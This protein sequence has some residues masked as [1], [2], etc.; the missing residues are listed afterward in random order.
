[1]Q[2]INWAIIEAS[3]G[4]DPRDYDDDTLGSPECECGGE[5]T[6]IGEQDGGLVMFEC[7]RCGGEFSIVTRKTPEVTTDR[8]LASNPLFADPAPWKNPRY[9]D[10]QNAIAIQKFREKHL[11]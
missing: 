2:P 3:G 5:S 8:Q 7:V 9:Q 11:N 4:Y 6:Y 10:K 1:M